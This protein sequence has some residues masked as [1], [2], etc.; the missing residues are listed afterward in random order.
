MSNGAHRKHGLLLA[1]AALFAAAVV[2][3]ALIASRDA[4]AGWLIGF[5]FWSEVTVG[6]LLLMMIHRLPGGR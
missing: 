5:V 2:A 6:S 1:G 4:A 3:D